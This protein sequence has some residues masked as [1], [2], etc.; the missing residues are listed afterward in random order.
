M[1]EAQKKGH[2]LDHRAFKGR[3]LAAIAALRMAKANANNTE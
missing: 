1:M 3:H 2:S